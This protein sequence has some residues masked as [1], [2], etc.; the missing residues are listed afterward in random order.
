[1]AME[2]TVLCLEDV[3]YH[4]SASRSGVFLAFHPSNIAWCYLL[5]L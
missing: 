3:A 4:L 1:M 2:D 5:H